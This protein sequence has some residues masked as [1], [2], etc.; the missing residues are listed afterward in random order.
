MG[1]VHC[2]PVVAS[3]SAASALAL[4]P[5]SDDLNGKLGVHQTSVDMPLPAAPSDSTALGN[6]NDAAIV[7][8]SGR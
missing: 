5:V 1:C 7:T 2:L 4:W 6:R 3:Q 8:T